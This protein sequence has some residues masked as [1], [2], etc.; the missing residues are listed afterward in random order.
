MQPQIKRM[1]GMDS[2]EKT[3]KF[4]NHKMVF[5]KA[6]FCALRIFALPLLFH[7]SVAHRPWLLKIYKNLI[8]AFFLI[9]VQ[10]CLPYRDFADIGTSADTPTPVKTSIESGSVK[11]SDELWERGNELARKGYARKANEY[12]EMAQQ[13]DSSVS[14]RLTKAEPLSPDSDKQKRMDELVARAEEACDKRDFSLA[15]KYADTVE[16][17]SPNEPRVEAIRERATLEDYKSDP[18]RPYDSMVKGLFDKAVDEYRSQNYSRALETVEKALEMDKDNQQVQKLKKLIESENS[19]TQAEKDVARAESLWEDGDL[20]DASQAVEKVLQDNPDYPQALALKK[21]MEESAG[22]QMKKEADASLEIAS[23]KEKDSKYLEAQ[24]YFEKVLKVD[25]GNPEAVK[26]LER[27][28]ALVD[29]VDG[30]LVD[31]EK[32]VNGD[33]KAKAEKLVAEIKKMDPQ[34]SA[35]KKWEKRVAAMAAPSSTLDSEAKADEAYNL[36]LQSYRNNDLMSAKK[37]WSDALELNPG[38]QQARRN[39]DRLLEDHPELKTSG[40]N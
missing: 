34:N 12:W 26:G 21:K 40:G 1:N 3:N 4:V 37:F 27:V 38:N 23:Q 2:R 13:L 7:L 10:A 11:R 31:L 18:D 19:E 17:L 6:S 5:E 15:L 36:G 14:S 22:E 20:E 16:S 29:P 25:P 8:I 24:K 35:L 32:A 39:L 33:E 9:T 30:K 28:R